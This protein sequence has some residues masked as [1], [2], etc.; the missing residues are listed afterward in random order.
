MKY[1]ALALMLFATPALAEIEEAR[2]LMEAGKFVEARE[3]LLPAA[4][5]GNADAEEL[6]GIMYAM[7]LGVPQDDVRAFEWYLRSAMKGHPGAQSGIGWYYEIG[8]GVA[9]DLTRAY[10]WYGLS[11]IGGDPDAAISIE[12]VTRKMTAEEIAHAQQLI[13]DYRPWL[14]PFR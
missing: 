13:D 2:D 7:G 14:Y 4:R 8:R 1:L 12:E 5:S 6:I 3:A 9:Q 11:M 10:M